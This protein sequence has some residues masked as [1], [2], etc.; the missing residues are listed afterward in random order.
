MNAEQFIEFMAKQTREAIESQPSVFDDI[1]SVD[2]IEG[3]KS[4]E[5]WITAYKTQGDSHV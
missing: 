4:V 5:R 1:R 3:W 2:R